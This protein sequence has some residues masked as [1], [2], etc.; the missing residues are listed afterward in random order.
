MKYFRWRCIL[1]KKTEYRGSSE[2]GWGGLEE[3]GLQEVERRSWDGA[4]G[5]GPPLHSGQLPFLLHRSRNSLGGHLSFSLQGMFWS[6]SHHQ[7]FLHVKHS[8]NDCFILTAYVVNM[9]TC[10][11]LGLCY[12]RTK[13]SLPQS[14]ELAYRENFSGILAL[15][16]FIHALERAPC[17]CLCVCTCM[18]LCVC[19]CVHVCTCVCTCVYV[20]AHVCCYFY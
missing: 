9:P 20:H 6:S 5:E 16:S 4:V 12:S 17:G 1:W 11:L 15:F 3:L 13:S 10:L 19:L 2:P 18:S 14:P 8:D 7:R